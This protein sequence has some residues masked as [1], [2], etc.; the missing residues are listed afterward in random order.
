MT[1]LVFSIFCSF[2]LRPEPELLRVLLEL[3]ELL[4]ELLPLLELLVPLVAEVHQGENWA[5]AK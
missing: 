3:E 1:A 5:E 2:Y 4:V